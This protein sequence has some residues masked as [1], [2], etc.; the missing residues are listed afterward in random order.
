[1]LLARILRLMVDAGL[2][3]VIVKAGRRDL[4]AGVTIN[5]AFIHVKFTW[6]VFSEPPV[7]LRHR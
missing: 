7:N 6:D 4:P 2:P 3:A 1:M 5:A